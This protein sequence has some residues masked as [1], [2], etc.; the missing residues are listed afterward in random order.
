MLPVK[1]FRGVE[2]YATKITATVVALG[3]HSFPSQRYSEGL[4][5]GV[6]LFAKQL[7]KAYFR[8]RR[9]V[10]SRLL[11]HREH[12]RVLRLLGMSAQ[13]RTLVAEQ[14]LLERLADAVM[15]VPHY[16]DQVRL[17]P[18]A[19]LHAESATEVIREFPYLDRQ[20][21]M[22]AP[23]R[24]LSDRY[25]LH[26]LHRATS[27]GST[28]EGVVVWRNKRLID[29]EMAFFVAAW[30]AYGFR[31]ERSRTLRV[32]R[33]AIRP[34]D[35][36]P[37][38]IQGNRLML[39]PRHTGPRWLDAIRR[40]IEAFAPDY[41]YGYPGAVDDLVRLFG[42]RM[43]GVHARAVLLTSEHA[44]DDQLHR[45]SDAFRAPVSVNYGMT[46]RTNIAF[47]ELRDGVLA[48]YR[49]EPLYGYSENR[50][51]NGL[52]EIIGTSLWNDVM[53]LIRYRTADYGRI[54]GDG[55]I[56]QLDGRGQDY[57]IDRFGLRVA[58]Q[59]IRVDDRSWSFLRTYQVRQ[60]RAGECRILVVPR[61]A[62]LDSTQLESLQSWL[63]RQWGKHFDLTVEQVPD[64]PLT[65]SGKRRQVIC[66]LH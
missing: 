41:I 38:W 59:M 29:I 37:T 2:N 34:I 7:Q 50:L 44:H 21:F 3:Q 66:D 13:E 23:E 5:P 30:S 49:F 48:P 57:L 20:T 17:D 18:Q 9:F 36:P 6:T 12:F 55:T 14:L 54:A 58:G 24:F 52:F 26:P 43:P 47:R 22:D 64:I 27:A 4:L 10:P 1:K 33:D 53:P 65:A 46:E 42:D 8:Y 63:Q 56:T 25:R 61:H 28:G 31:F 32:A 16:R 62:I 51:Q 15:H 60:S 45:I 11:Y 19:I 40:D 35:E 39:S